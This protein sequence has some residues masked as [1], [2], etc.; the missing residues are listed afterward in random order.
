MAIGAQDWTTPT[1]WPSTGAVATT[2]K[3]YYSGTGAVA[4]GT[5]GEDNMITVGSGLKLEVN[6]V[7][8]SCSASC[9]QTTRLIG[10][11]GATPYTFFESNFDIAGGWKL[12]PETIFPCEAGTDLKI[13]F[14]NNDTVTRTFTYIVYGFYTEK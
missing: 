6:Y 2:R 7:S 9:V 12:P 1:V 3:F 13:Q 8:V 10:Y 5:T 11:V 4:A 14:D